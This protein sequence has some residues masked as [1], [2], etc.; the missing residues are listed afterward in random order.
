ML[1]TYSEKIALCGKRPKLQIKQ[2]N[3]IM[4]N[5]KKT[6]AKPAIQRK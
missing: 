1:M 6:Y 2:K 5:S 4:S 3:Y